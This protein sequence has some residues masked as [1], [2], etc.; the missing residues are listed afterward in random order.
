[1]S[2]NLDIMSRLFYTPGSQVNFT[3]EN[4]K[5][6]NLMAGFTMGIAIG[7]GIGVAMDNI[8]MGIAIGVAMGVAFGAAFS[9]AKDQ[10]GDGV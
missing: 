4:M 7:V 8:G 5:K 3:G 2:N 6:R 10:N 9:K 1:M